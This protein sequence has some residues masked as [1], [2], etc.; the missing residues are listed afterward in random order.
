MAVNEDVLQN[1]ITSKR[2]SPIYLLYGNDSY[3]IQYYSEKLQK[4]ACPDNPFFNLQKFGAQTDLQD[5]YDAVKQYPMMAE[6][7]YVGL[8]DYDFYKCSA[9]DF[10]KLC[11]IFEEVEQGCVFVLSFDGIELNPKKESKTVKLMKLTEK[12]GGKVVCLDHRTPQKL[13][14]ML[15][16][17]AKKRGCTLNES[18]AKYLI[19][20]SGDDIALLRNELDKL[21]CFVKSGTIDR[22][23]IDNVSV[24]TV[25]SSLYDFATMILSGNL[26]GAL[27][28]LDDLFFMRIEPIVILN[29][30]S[31]VYVD[32]YRAYESQNSGVNVS[33]VA[34][35]FGYGNRAF[36]LKKAIRNLREFN[37]N[38]LDKSFE[39]LLDTDKSLKSFSLPERQILE[40]M[41][42]KLF[43]VLWGDG[44]P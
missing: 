22:K 27:K 25:D 20:K 30:V 39:I 31:G 16:T 35:E 43:S 1:D 40:Q 7:K 11:K 28:L 34:S 13:A 3:L 44:K 26:S 29:S 10:D 9:E 12:Y 17:G 32:L 18:D 36:V 23:I 4:L 2:L 37:L 38:K 21:C 14:R 8:E 6:S 33:E 15:V 19:E 41:T 24:K 5:V 42:V